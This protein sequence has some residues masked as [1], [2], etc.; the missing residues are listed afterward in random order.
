MTNHE[1]HIKLWDELA[2]TGE[3][4]KSKAFNA[5]FGKD[6]PRP[7]DYCFAC[8]ECSERGCLVGCDE[9]PLA[10]E[11]RKKSCLDG[12]FDKW[13]DAIGPEER[14]RLAAQI[15]DLPWKEKES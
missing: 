13:C 5:V 9:C 1:G 2:R 15:R 12:L 14:K 10:K 4:S 11:P 8:Q 3:P 7:S 6:V